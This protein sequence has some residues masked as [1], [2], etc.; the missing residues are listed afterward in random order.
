MI[1]VDEDGRIAVLEPRPTGAAHSMDTDWYA[2][3]RHGHV[4]RLSS[5][6][7]GSVPLTAHRQYWMELYK[8][9]ATA[10]LATLLP[11]PVFA[12]EAALE[13]ALAGSSDANERQ[14]LT[15][16]IA[17]DP[18]SRTAYGDWLEQQGRDRES[19]RPEAKVY[20]VGRE[21]RQVTF[22]D[23]PHQWTGVLRFATR[24]YLELFRAEHGEMARSLEGRLALPDAVE[25]SDLPQ[26][27]LAD[28]WAAGAIA[29]AF[30]LPERLDPHVVGLYTYSCAFSGPYTR[31][32]EPRTPMLVDALPEPIR[33]VVGRLRLSG[34]SFANTPSFDPEELVA[35]QRYRD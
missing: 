5:G 2:V 11:S 13:R 12:E 28:Y 9:L 16:I 20:V 23:L 1:V 34:L 29:S 33:S 21:L 7:E 10:R 17:G 31:V 30:V 24:E 35:C 3:D 14:L 19:W 25:V 15:A 27:I 6:E 32:D 26:Y 18:S 22:H 4:A 8:D